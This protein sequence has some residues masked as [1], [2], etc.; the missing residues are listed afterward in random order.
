[1]KL[2]DNDVRMAREYRAICSTVLED[3]VCSMMQ[4]TLKA[5]RA[6][7]LMALFE[8]YWLMPAWWSHTKYASTQ[9]LRLCTQ[10]LFLYGVLSQQVSHEQPSWCR[11]T[12]GAQC[13][14]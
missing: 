4:S 8:L 5:D 6:T 7:A 1:M 3:R 10:V 2:G 13:A 11:C 9:E 12:D 14:K